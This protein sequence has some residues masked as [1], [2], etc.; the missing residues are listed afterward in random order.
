M[1]L[2]EFITQYD[3]QG[4][5]VLLEGKREVLPE[6]RENLITLG[7]L[8]ASKTQYILFRSGNASGADEYFSQGVASID[9][10]RLQVITPYSNHRKKYNVASQTIGLDSIDLTSEPAVV[11]E[12][13]KSK[14]NAKL[15][16]DY[17]AGN[18]HAIKGAYLLRDTVKVIGTSAIP[19]C[20]F[21]LF[22]D[23]LLQPKSGGTGH[24]MQVC[25]EN[26]VPYLDQRV[27]MNWVEIKN[28]QI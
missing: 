18:K 4:S 10:R 16:T 14:K 23:D 2:Q 13:Q 22:Y 19:A 5:I 8:L 25:D 17:I 6:D 26:K 3:Y 20:T 1:T 12:T 7:N 27:W 28:N 11:Y 24:T 15:I 21:A 9:A